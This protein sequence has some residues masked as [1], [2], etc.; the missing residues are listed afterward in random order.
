MRF[1]LDWFRR[2]KEAPCQFYYP[3]TLNQYQLPKVSVKA[4]GGS[5]LDVDVGQFSKKVKQNYKVDVYDLIVNID[6]SQF[7]LC[8][9]ISRVRDK[10]LKEKYAQ[11]NALIHLALSQLNI[12][13]S[14]IT[15]QDAPDE[16]LNKQL[17]EWVEYIKNLNQEIINKLQAKIMQFNTTAKGDGDEEELLEE[18]R[19]DVEDV[20]PKVQQIIN[21]YSIDKEELQQATTEL[22]K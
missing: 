5:L 20:S 13:N 8:N 18:L 3:Q 2:N 17:L 21:D 14:L 11:I 15:N 12:L 9:A 19:F 10:E 4:G 7:S 22:S 1:S 6:Y 16:T